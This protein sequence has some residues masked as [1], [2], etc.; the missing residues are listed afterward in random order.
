MPCD[1]SKC[2]PKN[3][4][5]PSWISQRFPGI[6]QRFH[7]FRVFQ[8]PPPRGAGFPIL[9][10]AP[11]AVLPICCPA[12]MTKK[13]TDRKIT[14]RKIT[15]R[16]RRLN[17]RSCDLPVHDF[18]VYFVLNSMLIRGSLFITTDLAGDAENQRFTS[19]YG[20][21]RFNSAIPAGV[22]LVPLSQSCRNLSMR[23]KCRN[24]AS[25][26]RVSASESVAPNC[27]TH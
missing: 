16:R 3:L 1:P 5:G 22:V 21:R 14:D 20:N 9:P 26:T 13:Q 10:R 11:S 24:P 15:Q 8:R 2:I 6:S 25:V 4:P 17:Q 27:L 23:R 7:R 18:P 12:L 19:R